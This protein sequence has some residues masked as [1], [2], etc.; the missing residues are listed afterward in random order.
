MPASLLSMAWVTTGV[1]GGALVAGLV[2]VMPRALAQAA[3]PLAVAAQLVRAGQNERAFAELELLRFPLR[4]PERVRLEAGRRMGLG[5][6]TDSVIP[7]VGI[8]SPARRGG[9]IASV[10]LTPH[11]LHKAHAVTGAI[12]VTSCASISGTVA[13]PLASRPPGSGAIAAR[14]APP[15]A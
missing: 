3:D 8:L 7:K 12:C 2:A 14:R 13:A 15:H 11:D 1:A 5:D 10:Y 6:C 4:G 9:F